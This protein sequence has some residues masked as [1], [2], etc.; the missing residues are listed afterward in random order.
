MIEISKLKG[1]FQLTEEAKEYYDTWYH[2]VCPE[3]EK[4]GGATGAD[5]R[6]HTNVLKI[7]M[8][9]AVAARCELRVTVS[10][11][12][13]AIENVQTL[14]VNYKRLTMGSGKS[15]EAEPAVGVLRA[16]WDSEDYT[17]TRKELLYR[18]WADVS[19]ETL[20]LVQRTLE[21]AGL[22]KIIKYKDS[23]EAFQLTERAIKDFQN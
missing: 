16:L 9:T 18:C 19:N 6:I 4:R 5:G 1:F 8:I 12:K 15:K 17:L 10:D 2:K 14:F 7:A 3:L 23:S 20:D 13:V 11:I 22:V 21:G